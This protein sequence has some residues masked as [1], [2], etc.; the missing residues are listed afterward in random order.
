MKLSRT[1]LYF[2]MMFT[3]N[4]L[5]WADV[6]TYDTL[7]RLIE[8]DKA[9][10]LRA[11]LKSNPEAVHLRNKY[12]LPLIHSAAMTDNTDVVVVLLDS[13]AKL[14]SR[15]NLKRTPL[16]VAAGWSTVEMVEL[17]WS[18]GADPNSKTNRGGTPLDFAMNNFYQDKKDER[19][20]I[21]GFLRGQG[22]KM[23]DGEKQRQEIIQKTEAS[24]ASRPDIGPKPEQ[25]QNDDSVPIVKD[26]V[27]KITKDSSTKFKNW[28]KVS[29]LGDKWAVKVDIEY[30]NDVVTNWFYI[31]N[32]KVIGSK[33]VK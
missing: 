5:I 18:R 6:V 3:L 11:V 21:V 23:S 30:K 1:S 20:K 7:S 12:N 8:A 29:A 15:D 2:L 10:E 24:I 14:D 33:P 17:L 31:R 27:V 16:H 13:G 28:S 26:Y 25:L 4:P 19:V 9:D 32:G 22:S